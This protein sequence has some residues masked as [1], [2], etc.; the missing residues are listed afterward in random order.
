MDRRRFLSAALLTPLA[1]PLLQPTARRYP[2]QTVDDARRVFPLSVAS[3]DPTPYGV[4]LWTRL[5]PQ[6]WRPDLPLTLEVA[7]DEGF[8]TGVLQA[9][10]PP[11]QFDAQQDFTLHVDLDGQLEPGQRYFYRFIH[12][13]IASRTGRCHTLWLPSQALPS[14]TLGVVCCQ[15][16]TAGYYGAYH[17]LANESD[18]DF[19]VHLGDAIYETSYAVGGYPDRGIALPSNSPVALN[20]DDYRTLYRTYR[21][22]PFYQAALERHTFVFIWDDHETANDI[23][24]DAAQGCLGAPDHPY[25]LDAAYAA[26]RPALLNGLRLDS[27]RA[28]AEYTPA[29]L[30][31]DW[32]TNDPHRFFAINRDF[33]FGDLVHLFCSDE[34]SFRSPHPCGEGTALQRYA[35]L[36]CRE[37]NAPGRTMLGPAQRDWL[38]G[39]LLGSR[40]TWKCWANEVLLARMEIAQLYFNMDAWDGYGFER[41]QLLTNLALGG[42]ENLVVLTGDF[43]SYLASYVR[44]D[45]SRLASRAQPMGVE[46]MTPSVTSANVGDALAALPIPLP[47]DALEERVIRAANP[48]IQYFNSNYWGYSTVTFTPDAVSWTAYRVD[49]LH[50]TQE[51]GKTIL[52]RYT[53]P[54]GTPSLQR[55]VID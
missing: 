44:A 48:H 36:G 11:E 6:Q 26:N 24:W 22:D 43:H 21:S 33:R 39:G 34:R 19:V 9:T 37:R 3:G 46:F 2:A 31:I 23:Y 27:M 17:H 30:T 10:I 5:D 12:G 14:L 1:R 50:N 41:D 13:E 45:Y 55:A 32:T 51:A 49:K 18:V 28:W 47:A 25:T 42:L 7:S 15:D 40:A 38:Q 4:V 54:A 8:A 16:Y 52:V 53:S 35:T 20:L 29:R